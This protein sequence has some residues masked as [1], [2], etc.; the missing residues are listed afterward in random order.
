MPVDDLAA[1]ISLPVAAVVEGLQELARRGYV[2]LD[3]AGRPVALFPFSA[4]PTDHVVDIA[5][6]RRFAMCAV[7]ALGVAAM[8]GETIGIE[9]RC[10]ACGAP[11]RL[12]VAPDRVVTA[13]PQG[14][15]LVVGRRAT[16][17]AMAAC[18]NA[19]VYACTPACARRL[20]A[21]LPAADVLTVHDALPRSATLFA[22]FLTSPDLPPALSASRGSNGPQ[23]QG[24]EDRNC[25]PR[26]CV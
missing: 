22:R 19:T 21:R 4:I 17:D 23:G 16:D 3:A 15:R 12:S 5:G 18:C 6:R 1:A 7:D 10:A 26:G 11:V 25:N 20:A 14:T 8:V 13:M 9:S 24:G 2:C